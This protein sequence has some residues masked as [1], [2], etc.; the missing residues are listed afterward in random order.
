VIDKWGDKIPF[1]ALLQS[2]TKGIARGVS[3]FHFWCMSP[4]TGVLLKWLQKN[5]ALT[6]LVAKALLSCPDK[7]SDDG[8]PFLVLCKNIEAGH[9]TLKIL[10]EEDPDFAF[11]LTKEMLKPIDKKTE[12]PWDVLVE[13]E[14]GQE[15][16]KQALQQNLWVDGGSSSF[17]S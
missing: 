8:T 13:S 2:P 14:S 4:E 5:P 7:F 3:V 6:P 10:V 9:P 11:N 12:S 15:I 16:I 17:P 1:Q